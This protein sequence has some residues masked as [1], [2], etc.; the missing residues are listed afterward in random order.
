ML[1]NR[2]ANFKLNDEVKKE[3]KN[4]KDSII[5][6]QFTIPSP[7]TNMKF[8]FLDEDE[9]GDSDFSFQNDLLS[10]RA[11]KFLKDKDECLSAMILDDSIPITEK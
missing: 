3:I 10:N 6:K 8:N 9:K 7:K 4:A 11:Y 2:T 5:I 1:S